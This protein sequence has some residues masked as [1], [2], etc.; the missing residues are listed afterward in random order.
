MFT[1]YDRKLLAIF[2]R[3]EHC[4]VDLYHEM[5]DRVQDRF[6]DLDTRLLAILDEHRHSAAALDGILHYL[7]HG[8]DASQEVDEHDLSTAFHCD[9][10]WDR[11][12]QKM[13]Q[14]LTHLMRTESRYLAFL[15]SMRRHLSPAARAFTDTRLL[16][17]QRHAAQQLQNLVAT[18][19]AA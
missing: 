12:V 18:R 4:A 19:S 3:V 10:H 2:A 11:D 13:D 1:T 8:D 15:E 9:E 6:E 7:R 14:T 17:R 5:L 16:A